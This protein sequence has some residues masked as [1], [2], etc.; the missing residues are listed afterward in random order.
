MSPSDIHPHEIPRL[1][2]F[3]RAVLDHGHWR[4]SD[5]ACRTRNGDCVPADVRAS[6]IVFDGLDHV[7]VVIRELQTE[8][9]AEVG[10]SVRKVAHDL[11]NTLATA[12]LL[13][14]RLT[15]AHDD[16]MRRNA[17]TLTRVIDRATEMCSEIVATGRTA[18]T[19][20]SPMRFLL[21]DLVEDLQ[22]S[23]AP[24][25]EDAAGF[26]IED[27][28]PSLLD[29]DYDK[30]YRLF[31]NLARNAFAA[32]ASTVQ[33]ATDQASAQPNTARILVHDDGPGLPDAVQARLFEEK[34]SGNATSGLGLSIAAEIASAH[35]GQLSLLRTGSKG[36]SFVLTLPQ[37]QPA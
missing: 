26:V 35:G 12:Q 1:D 24:E 37:A 18:S 10:R 8:Q 30:L 5:L 17:Q 15:R 34:A 3:L 19:R 28:E 33:I 25:R 13:S 32:G 27:N 6:R 31:L 22:A 2:A 4:S 9:L 29:A 20:L 21:V 11:R 7:L 14:E 16:G 36:T 23:I